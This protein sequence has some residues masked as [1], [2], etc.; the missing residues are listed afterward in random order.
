MQF[1]AKFLTH[2]YVCIYAAGDK[3]SFEIELSGSA[4]NVTWLKDNKP[5]EDRMADRVRKTEVSDHHHRLE[6]LNCTEVDSGLYT[7]RANNGS[8]SSTCSAQLVVEKRKMRNIL[9]S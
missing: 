4:E 1:L 6:I 9:L 7:A 5:L 3:A 8:E 2:L